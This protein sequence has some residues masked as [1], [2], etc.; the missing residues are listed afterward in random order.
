[1]SR[2]HQYRFY[3]STRT[4]LCPTALDPRSEDR[5]LVPPLL[6]ERPNGEVSPPAVLSAALPAPSLSTSGSGFP[7]SL[8]QVPFKKNDSFRKRQNQNFNG[9][10]KTAPSLFKH[11]LLHVEFRSENASPGWTSQPGTY[12]TRN[13]SSKNISSKVFSLTF[14]GSPLPTEVA[15]GLQAVAFSKMRE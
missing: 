6:G 13:S 12:G 8:S 4:R 11:L 2:Q 7:T 15:S 5:S 3:Y 9:K 14:S 10:D 1:M